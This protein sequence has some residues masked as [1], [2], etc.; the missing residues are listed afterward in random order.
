M[1]ALMYGYSSNI[2]RNHS[3]FQ[4]IE[5]RYQSFHQQDYPQRGLFLVRLAFQNNI[6]GQFLATMAHFPWV[7]SD[8]ELL[9]V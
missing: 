5:F 6:S 1:K 8:Q 4:M 7:G 2:F 9:T 3:I